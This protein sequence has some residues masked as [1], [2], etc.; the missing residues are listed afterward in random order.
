MN[1]LVMTFLIVAVALAV[2]IPGTLIMGR[3]QRNL[4]R[5]ALARQQR[6]E[7]QAQDAVDVQRRFIRSEVDHALLAAFAGLNED[8]AIEDA[9]ADA[10]AADAAQRP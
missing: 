6:I 2:I 9:A 8:Q 4:E 5:A 1:D 3:V 7:A 10:A